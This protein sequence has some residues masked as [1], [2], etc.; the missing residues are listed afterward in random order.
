[1]SNVLTGVGLREKH[2][3]KAGSAKLWS[4]AVTRALVAVL[5]IE[6]FDSLEAVKVERI[7]Q[8]DHFLCRI[9]LDC[10]VLGSNPLDVIDF[11][12]TYQVLE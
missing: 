8:N 7:E 5:S 11:E 1:M 2:L 9:E 6:A 10:V 4:Q 12:V 3:V